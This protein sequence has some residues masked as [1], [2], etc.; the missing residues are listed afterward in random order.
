MHFNR[1]RDTWSTVAM[2]RQSASSLNFSNNESL[3]PLADK[4]IQ[5]GSL[6]K[7]VETMQRRVQKKTIEPSHT[8]RVLR[9]A[10]DPKGQHNGYVKCKR[11]AF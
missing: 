3:N 1:L 7:A 9:T 2:T 4:E 11:V 5:G 8:K 10:G 6:R